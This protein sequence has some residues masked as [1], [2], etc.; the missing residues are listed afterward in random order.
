MLA[1]FLA[2]LDALEAASSE[3]D[4]VLRSVWFNLGY[5]DVTQTRYVYEAGPAPIAG[6][7]KY[8]PPEL[9][10]VLGQTKDATEALTTFLLE[11]LGMS[12]QTQG[13]RI[14]SP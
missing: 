5:D 4:R 3:R 6:S 8:K 7:T 12:P 10:R 9:T 13:I 2:I 14:A 1:E 11:R